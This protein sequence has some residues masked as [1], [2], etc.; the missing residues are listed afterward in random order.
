MNAKTSPHSV[1]IKKLHSQA[2]LPTRR[3]GDVGWDLY[4]ISSEA[5]APGL[6]KVSTG[7]AIELPE[8][9]W[10]QIENRSSMG[11]NGYDVHGG[12]VDNHYR[13]EIIVVL[14]MHGGGIPPDILPGGKIAQLIVRRQ[15]DIGWALEESDTLSDTVRGSNGFGSTGR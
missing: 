6:I 9:Y 10:G 14:A 7:I 12:I 3:E 11:K 4:A 15:E 8:G 2:K 5:L 13:G 1:K